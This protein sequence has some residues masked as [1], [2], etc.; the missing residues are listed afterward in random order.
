MAP[1]KKTDVEKAKSEV[2]KS[3]RAV[4]KAAEKLTVPMNDQPFGRDWD[5]TVSDV[6]AMDREFSEAAVTGNLMDFLRSKLQSG[7]TEVRVMQVGPDGRLTDVSDRVT[8]KD[9]S[10]EHIRGV[11]IEDGKT[12]PFGR[13][14]QSRDA[15]YQAL[16]RILPELGANS[17]KS[18][19]IRRMEL[20]LDESD[21]I[22]EHWKK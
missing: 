16:R 8:P 11:Q 18:E 20:I 13:S 14:P 15:A 6:D 1:K 9:L 10:P 3:A 5:Q 17:G 22:L 12:V 7:D 2:G 4:G 21:K 19:A